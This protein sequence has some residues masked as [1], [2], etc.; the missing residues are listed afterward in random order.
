M[1]ANLAQAPHSLYDPPL[2]PLHLI[3]YVYDD[4][5]EVVYSTSGTDLIRT[6]QENADP[7]TQVAV[8]QYITS[9]TPQFD[10]ANNVLTLAITATVASKSES[11]TYEV[12]PRP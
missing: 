1:F 6:Y 12:H 7:S 10:E 8:A 2:W 3:W 4:K 5:Y 11:R 9:V